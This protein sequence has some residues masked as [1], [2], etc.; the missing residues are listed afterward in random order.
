MRFLK[1]LFKFIGGLFLLFIVVVVVVAIFEGTGGDGGAG[2]ASSTPAEQAVCSRGSP[3][4]R[5]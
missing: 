2:S 4:L 3:T 1:R 5:W